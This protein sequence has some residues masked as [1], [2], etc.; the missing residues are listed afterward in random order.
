MDLSTLENLLQLVFLVVIVT[1][2]MAK[3]KE[4]A[5]VRIVF[6]FLL[7]TINFIQSDWLFATVWGIL[8]VLNIIR[9]ILSE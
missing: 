9:F 4:A 7:G 2:W 3:T 5:A 8:M 1:T 6:T